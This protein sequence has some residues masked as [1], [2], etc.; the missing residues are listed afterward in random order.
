MRWRWTGLRRLCLLGWLAVSA[1][2]QTLISDHRVAAFRHPRPHLSN[3]T[4]LFVDPFF[5]FWN[6]NFLLHL[7]INDPLLKPGEPLQNDH[8]IGLHSASRPGRPR[9]RSRGLFS[10]IKPQ[11]GSHDVSDC[12]RFYSW[13]GPSN[14]P[15][16]T[17]GPP[18]QQP[19]PAALLEFNNTCL[20]LRHCRHPPSLYWPKR[21]NRDV[22]IVWQTQTS[23]CFTRLFHQIIEK[24]SGDDQYEW[25][26]PKLLGAPQ[27]KDTTDAWERNQL[28]SLYIGTIGADGD[29]DGSPM[30]MTASLVSC[31]SFSTCYVFKQ[32]NWFLY[33]WC[34]DNT[35]AFPCSPFA[36]CLNLWMKCEMWN[37]SC[38]A[39]LFALAQEWNS[40]C[41]STPNSLL[42]VVQLY[43]VL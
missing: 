27:K 30:M 33:L 11:S 37:V 2:P 17:G 12:R 7:P 9:G 19:S 28:C 13:K 6:T 39:F 31:S 20:S 43:G 35:Q 22:I 10:T 42:W 38:Q 21:K 8:P 40:S 41:I 3:Q 32:Y 1:L 24:M 14:R 34:H 16:P 29:D 18:E 23:S 15:T 25:R 26:R 4:A 5:F 36:S